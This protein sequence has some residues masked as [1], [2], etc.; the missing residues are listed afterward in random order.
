[1][2]I[3]THWIIVSKLYDELPL[4]KKLLIKRRNFL[5]GSIKPDMVSK[6]KL[7]KHYRD[8]SYEAIIE[9]INT[10]LNVQ[11]DDI[12]SNKGLCGFSQDLG[13]VC[14][15]ICD[16]FCVPHNERWEFKHSM[17]AHLNYEKNLN[18]KAKCYTFNKFLKLKI[19]PN[20]SIETF[21]KTIYVSYMKDKSLDTYSKDLQYSYLI[22][23][24]VVDAILDETFDSYKQSLIVNK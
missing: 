20:I 9:K 3:R 24:L 21:L 6:Y 19:N 15:F 13:V 11:W 5:Y 8:E 14:H 12:S 22:C 23:Y 16:F 18:K 4:S 1:M 10:L 2:D 7:T 17:K